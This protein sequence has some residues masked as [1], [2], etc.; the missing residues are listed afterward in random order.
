VLREICVAVV[1][2]SWFRRRAARS[3]LPLR[4][5]VKPRVNVN[6]TLAIIFARAEYTHLT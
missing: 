2:S 6:T 4:A 1:P 5:V 3:T